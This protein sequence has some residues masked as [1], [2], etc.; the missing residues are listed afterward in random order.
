MRHI[1]IRSDT[2]KLFSHIVIS[3]AKDTLFSNMLRYQIATKPGHRAS[4]HLY[5]VKSVLAILQEKKEACIFS[6]WDLKAYFDSEVL[7]DVMR[8]L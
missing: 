8:E 3:Q 1:H 6:T 7:E 4:E 2:S 5:L